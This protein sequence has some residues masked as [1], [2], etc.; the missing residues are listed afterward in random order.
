M[1]RKE[2]RFQN[3][4]NLDFH[5]L[6]IGSERNLDVY[7]ERIKPKRYLDFYLKRINSEKILDFYSKP[8][9]LERRFNFY[10]ERLIGKK[11]I[12][13]FD[14]IQFGKKRFKKLIFNCRVELINFLC[15]T[16]IQKKKKIFRIV[17]RFKINEF[18]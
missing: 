10:S 1:I 18:F 2:I 4:W 13:Q 12:L 14:L 7:S 9:E 16:Q 15:E 6:Q 8:I 17:T 11:F 3:G 5:F